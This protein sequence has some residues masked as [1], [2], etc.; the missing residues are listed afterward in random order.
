MT[1]GSKE[2]LKE[3]RCS[4][5]WLCRAVVV[6]RGPDLP[7]LVSTPESLGS[8]D[9]STPSVLAP[10]L[11]HTHVGCYMEGETPRFSS[12]CALPKLECG[13]QKI[14]D[15]G[16]ASMGGIEGSARAASCIPCNNMHA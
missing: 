11:S 16:P 15:E 1:G 5:G 2:Q 7:T 12:T 10:C 14:F 13:L 4:S 8:Q 9:A 6:P 3:W